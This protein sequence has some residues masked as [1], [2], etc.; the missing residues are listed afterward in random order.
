VFEGEN[1]GLV[2]AELEL[3]SRDTRFDRPSWLGPEV[4]EDPR[5]FNIS[6]VNNPYSDWNIQKT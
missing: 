6:L 4:S 1:K 2:I 5:Y 3:D